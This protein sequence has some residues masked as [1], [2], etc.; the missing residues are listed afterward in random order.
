MPAAYLLDLYDTVA[1]GDWWAWTEELAGLAGVSPAAITEGFHRTR[2]ARNTGG[3]ATA[4][5]ALRDVLAA[6]GARQPDPALLARIVAAETA[7]DDRVQLFEEAL[8]AIETLRERGAR[9]ALV[10]NCSNSTRQIVDRLGLGDVF[11]AV[12]LSFEL[13][14]R[15]PDEGIY[16]AALDAIEAS[17]ADALFVDDQTAYCDGARAVGMDTRLIVR[18]EWAPPEGFAAA[19]GHRV[20]ASL[21]D[22]L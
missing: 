9:L 18:P 4:E 8:P 14:V 20:I 1:K 17:P 6:A 7:F 10:S 3:Y 16:R 11:D 12:V 2:A 5:E 22:L 19:N 13:G 21:A 15:K